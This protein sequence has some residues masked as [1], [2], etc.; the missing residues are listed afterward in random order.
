MRKLA[1]IVV[2]LLLAVGASAQNLSDLI[3][4]EAC[5]VNSTG[6]V[7]ANGQRR[8]WMEITNVSTGTVNYA[9]C[10]ISDD[11]SDLQKFMV[12]KGVIANR[13]GARQVTVIWPSFEILPGKTLY[14]VST[15]GKTVIDT[16]EIPEDIPADMS[17][18]KVA[19]DAR[20]ID[21]KTDPS[22]AV[23]TPGLINTDGSEE[24][25]SNRM[26]RIDPHGWTL[27]VTSVSVV[28]GALLILLII[29]TISGNTISGK[30]KRRLKK[31][32][33]HSKASPDAEIAA[34]A[35]ALELYLNDEV[36]DKESYRITITSVTPRWSDKTRN[37]RKPI[38]K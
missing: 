22:P 11:K 3:I 15:D 30:Y 23:P 27:T 13:L 32:F 33:S 29:F 18:R 10:F 1:G 26:G 16:I 36:H 28:F 9:G 38:V 12:P 34:I 5:P 24:S 2:S 31:E 8:S 19:R 37:F 17:V 7:D 4:S 25:G 20:R 14:L 6:I 21:F 35:M